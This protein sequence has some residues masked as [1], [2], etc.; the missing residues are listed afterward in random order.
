M[1]G[2]RRQ[3]ES[4]FLPLADNDSFK[5][6]SGLITQSLPG[7]GWET[8][9]SMYADGQPSLVLVKQAEWAQSIESPSYFTHE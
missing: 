7:R 3:F 6:G 9:V 4:R 1:T 8:A 2:E 5:R